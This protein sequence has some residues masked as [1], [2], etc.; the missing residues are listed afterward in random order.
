M[1]VRMT[2]GTRAVSRVGMLAATLTATAVVELQMHSRCS[3]VVLPV[4]L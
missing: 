4:T 3:F 1:C 2:P